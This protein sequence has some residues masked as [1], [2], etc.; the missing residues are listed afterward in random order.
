MTDQVRVGVIGTSWYAD[1]AHLPR[2]KSHQCAELKAICGRNRARA[3]EMAKKYG[4][5]LVFTDYREMI[6]KGDL[7]AVIVSTPDDL[8]YPMTMDALDAG[9]HVLCEKPF[10]L[11]R[12]QAKEMYE[13]AQAA[14]VKHMVCFTYRWMPSYRYLK[15]LVDEGYVGRCFHCRFSY[16]GG[17]AR[18]AQYRW[19]FDRRRGLG[20]LG[21]LGSHMIDLAR[22]YVG[23]IVRVSACLNAFVERPGPGGQTLDPANDAAFLAVE[24]ESGALGVI[25]ISTVAHTGDRG[26]EQQVRLYGQS[27]T[28]ATDWS[29]IE[30]EIRGVRQDEKQWQ[31]LSVPDELWDGVDRAQPPIMQVSEAF[32]RQPIG[33]R[34]F[35]DAILQDRPVVPSFYDG[36]KAQEVIDAALQSH[37]QGRWV[38]L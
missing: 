10:A 19:K 3:E 16:L 20:A 9:L 11:N 32:L 22:W 13:K 26:Q 12:T 21:D 17:Y 4:I 14:G 1:L 8:H 38:S 34:L 18:A 2:V 25:E 29:F 23:D 28:L 36:L 15:Q 24:F 37:E 30:G 35:I 6:E 27:G 33:D 5:P 7:D 31:A